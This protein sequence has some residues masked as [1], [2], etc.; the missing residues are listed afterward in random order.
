MHLLSLYFLI[1]NPEPELDARVS[2]PAN[3]C[4]ISDKEQFS[5]SLFQLWVDCVWTVWFYRLTSVKII[6]RIF[7]YSLAFLL[8]PFNDMFPCFLDLYTLSQ[9][10][11]QMTFLLSDFLFCYLCVSFLLLRFYLWSHLFSLTFIFHSWD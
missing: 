2:S 6:G 8:D 1:F 11:D 10:V 7:C 5:G 9:N 4:L 3:D